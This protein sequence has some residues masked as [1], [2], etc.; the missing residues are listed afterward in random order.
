MQ[1]ITLNL[2]G[3]KIH[4]PL[5]KFINKNKNKTD[6][7]TFQEV[8]KSDR[9]VLSHGS[10]SNLIEE[11]IKALPEFNYYFA[12]TASG[13][14]TRGKV[15]FPIE[16][17]QATFV[18]KNINVIRNG[19]VFTHKKYNDVKKYYED[20]RVDFPRLFVYSEIENEGKHFMVLNVHG[21]WEPAPKYDT[22][23]R[24]KQS[25]MIIDFVKREKIPAIVA[26]DF[27]LRIDTKA[28]KMFEENKFRNLVKESGALTTRSILYDIKWRSFDKYADYILTS[29]GIWVTNFKVMRAKVSD[30]L[31]L[32][33]KFEI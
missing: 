30:H 9:N 11:L 26:G 17:G 5:F 27:N 22:D 1:L 14:D 8:F 28:L 33:M 12:S 4:T 29:K 31:P 13:H 19:K 2:W 7:F 6:I 10:Y 24:Y 18:K 20:G 21:F 23:E 3:G 25:Q 16:F 15:D 32:F